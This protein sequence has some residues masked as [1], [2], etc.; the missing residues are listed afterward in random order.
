MALENNL[1]LQV[2]S[3]NPQISQTEVEREMAQFD[4]TIDATAFTLD[5][6]TPAFFI[7]QPLTQEFNQGRV[8]FR[9]SL[10]LGTQYNVG[11]RSFRNEGEQLGS[12]FNQ[13]FGPI[14]F[15]EFTVGFTQ[16][17]LRNRGAEA[18][19]TLIR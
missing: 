8:D 18:N 9:D 5:E 12:I 11:V 14:F 1:D 6:E 4:S 16:P 15:S 7:G 10:A 19:K 3:F 13:P 2:S 17:L